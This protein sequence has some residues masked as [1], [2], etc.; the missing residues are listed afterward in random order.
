MRTLGSAGVLIAVAGAAWAQE[1]PRYDPAPGCKRFADAGGTYSEQVYALC[2]AQ[3]QDAYDKFK[4]Q[5]AE[6][7]TPIRERCD[8]L[9]SAGGDGGSY[10]VLQLCLQREQSVP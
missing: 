6:I 5:W 1:L 7:P 8:Q 4:R 9:G 10:R 2:L 3:E